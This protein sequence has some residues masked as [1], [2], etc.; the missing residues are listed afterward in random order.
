MGAL[1]RYRTSYTYYIFSIF[2][3]S[4]GENENIQTKKAPRREPQFYMLIV[5][6]YDGVCDASCD[7]TS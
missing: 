6:F 7:D 1:F 2:F 3:D 4:S 5:S